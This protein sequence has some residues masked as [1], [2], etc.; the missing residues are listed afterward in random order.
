MYRHGNFCWIHMYSKY[1]INNNWDKENPSLVSSGD[2]E[3]P[4]RG[5]TVPVGNEA[6]PSFPLER[7]ARGLGFPGSTVHQWSIL[8]LTYLI[9]H[10]FSLTINLARHCGLPFAT[11]CKVR[12]TRSDVSYIL[13]R[14][15]KTTM[16]E[17]RNLK[18]LAALNSDFLLSL[19][20]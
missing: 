15:L 6:M 19:H 8:F 5:S 4:T 7:W 3:I 11:Y 18:R 10:N 1:R 13:K 16:I 17:V 2:R 20:G 9:K 14:F 12:H